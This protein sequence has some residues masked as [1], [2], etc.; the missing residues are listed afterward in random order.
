MRSFD[1]NE[2]LK[3][4]YTGK[5]RHP[6]PGVETTDDP[7]KATTYIQNIKKY[8]KYAKYPDKATTSFFFVLPTNC[9]TMDWPPFG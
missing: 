3:D 9:H 4:V 6:L 8:T 7:D 5:N 1:L 2:C